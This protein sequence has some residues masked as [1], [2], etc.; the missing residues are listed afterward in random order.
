[1]TWP[2]VPAN[3]GPAGPEREIAFTGAVYVR[4]SVEIAGRRTQV[5]LRASLSK[6]GLIDPRNTTIGIDADGNGKID[7]RTVPLEATDTQDEDLVFKVGDRFVLIRSVDP[8]TGSFTVEERPASEYIVIDRAVGAT[9]PDFAFVDFSGERRH[10]SDYA[11]HVVLLDFWGTWCGP[12]VA[13]IPNLAATYEALHHR[14]LEIIGLNIETPSGPIADVPKNEARA[15]KFIE[16]HTMPWIQATEVSVRDLAL[17][18]FRVPGFPTTIL[19]GRDGRIVSVGAGRELRGDKLLPTI[20]A[21][22]GAR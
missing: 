3:K 16:S 1:V 21:A 10:L 7:P 8:G 19:I 5:T 2:S 4:G 12:C 15:R 6:G 18:R 14:G 22:M 9:V 20:E 11:G 13:E 17:K